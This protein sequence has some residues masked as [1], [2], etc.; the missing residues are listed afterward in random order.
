M[1]PLSVFAQISICNESVCWYIFC[2]E[3]HTDNGDKNKSGDNI[4]FPPAIAA[5]GTSIYKQL[6]HTNVVIPSPVYDVHK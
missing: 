3:Y 4:I 1:Q 5:A 6:L 2:S